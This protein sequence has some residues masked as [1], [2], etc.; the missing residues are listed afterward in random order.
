MAVGAKEKVE[1]FNKYSSTEG[2]GGVEGQ[3]AAYIL[4]AYC[5]E[6][7]VEASRK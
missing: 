4:D 5:S 7:S 2:I 6:A 3:V 1:A